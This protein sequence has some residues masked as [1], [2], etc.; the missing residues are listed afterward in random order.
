[1]CW[2]QLLQSHCLG[3]YMYGDPCSQWH[4]MYPGNLNYMLVTPLIT[5]FLHLTLLPTGRK[6]CKHSVSRA[7]LRTA[8]LNQVSL[9][10]LQ[11]TYT[12]VTDG[13]CASLADRSLIYVARARERGIRSLTVICHLLI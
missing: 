3:F 9:P 5:V 10:V 6:G 1:M 13:Y 11:G 12:C 7:T 8:Q 4:S 2:R